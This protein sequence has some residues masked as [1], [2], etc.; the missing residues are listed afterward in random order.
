MT[1]SR[2]WC[3]LALVGIA[4]CSF[5]NYQVVPDELGSTCK[6]GVRDG[7]ETGVDCGPSCVACP[8]CS[9]G[10]RN[11]DE[12]GVDCGG[13]CDD[14]P[15][16]DDGQ[17]NGTE[18]DTDCGGTCPQRCGV[19]SRCRENADCRSL[20]CDGVCQPPSCLD[21]VRNGEETGID[22]GGNCDGCANGSACSVDDDCQSGRCQGE[23]C[24]DARC[25]DEAINGEETDVDCG[26]SECAPCGAPG[27][28]KLARDCES[29]NCKA[30]QCVAPSCSDVLQN[31]DES[32]VDCG[33]TLCD[34]CEVGSSCKSSLDCA[35]GL[36]Q[37][38]TCVPENPMGQPLSR[39]TWKLTSSEPSTE[40]G[41]ASAFDGNDASAWTSGTQQRAGMYVD[42]DLGQQSIF[43]KALIKTV[44]GAHPADFPSFIDAYVS[45]DG[46]FGEPTLPH[47]Q[48]NQWLWI[49]FQGAQVG[50]YLR[51]VITEPSA[52]NWSIDEL[53]VYN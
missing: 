14:C 36:C 25:T 47:L 44:S 48:G 19:D 52:Q 12:T 20:V 39:G 8:L 30:S 27:K 40:S 33:G 28:C 35:S 49:D 43:F 31:Q 2:R 42:I 41:N 17:Q 21:G 16:C 9:D 3:A 4:A 24:V 51:F 5:P 7:D 50:R 18:S 46:S 53:Y 45:S 29:R 34:A 22:C 13:S 38:S 15:T 26:G 32:D 1:G 37:R 23:V 11:G 6:N 10:M